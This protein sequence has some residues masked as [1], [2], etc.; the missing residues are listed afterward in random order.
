MNTKP[1][2]VCPNASKPESLRRM[3]WSRLPSGVI[4]E[5]KQYLAHSRYSR[6]AS[7]RK[8][9]KGTGMNEHSKPCREHGA[10][11]QDGGRLQRKPCERDS[12]EGPVWGRRSPYHPPPRPRTF[13]STSARQSL[14]NWSKSPWLLRWFTIMAT[15]CGSPAPAPAPPGPL[16][17]GPAPGPGGGGG[18]CG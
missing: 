10:P 18:G 4:V 8:E 12:P 16:A 17:P 15:S 11:P 7:L 5:A 6:N 1:S 14:R 3:T 9:H 13:V 2:P